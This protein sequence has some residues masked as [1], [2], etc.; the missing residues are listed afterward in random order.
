MNII[1]SKKSK[2]RN[3]FPRI[4]QIDKKI[5]K[6]I[7]LQWHKIFRMNIDKEHEHLNQEINKKINKTKLKQK[8]Q[9]LIVNSPFIAAITRS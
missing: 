1:Y 9:L 4:L 7:Q 2:L 3:I 6:K 5:N 8:K